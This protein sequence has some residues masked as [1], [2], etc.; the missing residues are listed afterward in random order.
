MERIQEDRKKE[1]FPGVEI[2][3]AKAL[4]PESWYV[5]EAE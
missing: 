1:S 2:A 5:R 3:Y 4:N